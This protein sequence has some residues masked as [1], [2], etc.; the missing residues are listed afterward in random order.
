MANMTQNQMTQVER[1]DLSVPSTGTRLTKTR[2]IT[3]YLALATAVLGALLY[4]TVDAIDGWAH[5]VVIGAI[6]ATT[7]G[8]M[9][10]LSPKRR[11]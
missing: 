7:I 11:S 10:A 9:I 4:A 3:A 2:A 8:A 6:V 1:V 5:L